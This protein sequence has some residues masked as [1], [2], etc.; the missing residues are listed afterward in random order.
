M[1]RDLLNGSILASFLP[2]IDFQEM[3]TRNNQEYYRFPAISNNIDLIIS[4]DKPDIDT[5]NFQSFTR[6]L[7]QINQWYRWFDRF[8]E[9]FRPIFEW[10]K[11]YN[12]IQTHQFSID[13]YT[14]RN[15]PQLTLIDMKTLIEKLAGFLEPIIGLHRLCYLFNCLNSFRILDRGTLNTRENIQKYLVELKRLQPNNTF[16]IQPGGSYEH[17]VSINDRQQVQWSLASGSSS[18]DIEIIYQT[19]DEQKILF[20]EGNVAIH[21]QVLHGQ[22]ESSQAGRLRIIL[23]N[24]QTNRSCPIWYRLKTTNLPI[25]QLFQGIFHLF[26]AKFPHDDLVTID[27]LNRILSEVFTFIDKLSDGSLSLRQ[28]KDLQTIFCDQSI[29]IA[30]EVKKLYHEQINDNNIE[31]VCQWLR[32]YQY[33]SHINI[34]IKCIELFDILPVDQTRDDLRRLA[35]NEDCSLREITDAFRPL[36]QRFRKLS[37]QHLQLIKTAV[38]CAN[39]V[40]MMKKAD[41]YS[42]NGQRRFQDLKDNLTTQFQYQER[43]N[44]ILNSWIMTHTCIEPFVLKATNFDE[45]ISRVTDIAN[46]DESSLNHIKSMTI[47]EEIHF[48]SSRFSCK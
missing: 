17:V 36:E 21:R 33:Y 34:I 20:K 35:G 38:D 15:E 41:F 37:H 47:H 19:S 29:H 32:I 11:T 18:C 42:N 10:L 43:N 5:G 24:T 23:K 3:F 2:R 30:N 13:F 39:V 22:F 45:F 9:V 31:Q 12:L 25:C 7:E 14:I 44:M 40:K 1:Y 28:M 48:H 27:Q 8:C 4:L 46:F 16:S 6:F 26:Y